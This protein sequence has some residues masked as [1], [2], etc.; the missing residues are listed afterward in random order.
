MTSRLMAAEAASICWKRAVL[1]I[2]RAASR[3]SLHKS[4]YVE[5]TCQ[6]P[7]F[8]GKAAAQINVL[9]VLCPLGMCFPRC[10]YFGTSSRGMAMMPSCP[11]GV[12]G[13]LRN[14]VLPMNDNRGI[15]L[16]SMINTV[17]QRVHLRKFRTLAILRPE[18][19]LPRK[20][21]A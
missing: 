14:S 6:A 20:Y 17:V 10:I 13:A 7:S 18:K 15:C 8:D 21:P 16:L 3:N 12:V 9:D 11:P 1:P 19:S 4:I 5:H 2:T